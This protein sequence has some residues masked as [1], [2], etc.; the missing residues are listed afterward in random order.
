MRRLVLSL[1]FFFP[2][3]LFAADKPYDLEEWSTAELTTEILRRLDNQESIA[4]LVQPAADRGIVLAF[5]C[6]KGIQPEKPQRTES[7][8]NLIAL[9]SRCRQSHHEVLRLYEPLGYQTFYGDKAASEQAPFALLLHLTAMPRRAA[10]ALV[11]AAPLPTLDWLRKQSASDTPDLERLI[12][13]W[14]QWGSNIFWLHE[15]QYTAEIR[16]LLP[17]FFKNKPVQA[18]PK[19]M[20]ALV[21]L[22]GEAR[23]TEASEFVLQALKHTDTGIRREACRALQRLGSKQPPPEFLTLFK[24]E[25]DPQVLIAW[26][27]ALQAWASSDEA[28]AAALDAFEMQKDAEARRALLFSAAHATWKQRAEL[29]GKALKKDVDPSVQGVALQALGEKPELELAKPILEVMAAYPEPPTQL[30]DAL[31]RLRD[32]TAAEYLIQALR[33]SKNP[34]VQMKIV[35]ALEKIGGTDAERELVQQLQTTANLFFAQQVAGALGRMKAKGADEVLA[36]MA[37]D[38]TAPL[39]VRMQCIWALGGFPTPQANTSLKKM[40]G[41]SARYFGFGAAGTETPA[42]RLQQLEQARLLLKLALFQHGDKEAEQA[43]VELYHAGTP[44]TQVAMLMMFAQLKLDHPVI[45]EGLN[46]PE[47]AIV[48]AAVS[49][50]GASNPVKYHT[51]LLELRDSPYIKAI[52]DGGLNP[53]V[54]EDALNKAI[55]AGEKSAP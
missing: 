23:S 37:E 3:F 30:I 4:E 5:A 51:K 25:T 16:A 47:F 15:R 41:D 11:N 52:L 2:T 45:L 18:E 26:M 21:C 44:T 48:V 53:V 55:Q 50:A 35:L 31:G 32:P 46:A 24:T 42:S 54:M 13:I 1:L 49:A 40:D 20:T 10:E 27:E 29:L 19:A 36:G 38:T 8:C 28:G 7:L 34:A 33:K 14:T 9:A 17:A 39:Q 6:A 43:A 12:P 22:A